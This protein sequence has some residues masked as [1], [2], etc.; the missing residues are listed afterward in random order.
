MLKYIIFLWVL[1]LKL[2]YFIFY[3]ILI[4]IFM[5]LIIIILYLFNILIRIIFTFLANSKDIKFCI[6][7]EFTKALVLKFS[8]Y[9]NM[10]NS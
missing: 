4:Y 10:Y 2:I 6:Y 5:P 7:L 8:N 1:I 3:L 9:I